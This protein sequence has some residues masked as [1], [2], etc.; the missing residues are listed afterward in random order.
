MKR[1]KGTFLLI[2]TLFL[3]LFNS[4]IN[5]VTISNQNKKIFLSEA[6]QKLLSEDPSFDF[7]I[8]L[9]M[10]LGHFPSVSSCIIKNNSIV[11]Y[12]GYGKAKIF[13]KKEPTSDTIYPIGSISKTVTATAAM[14][15]W[16]KGLFNLDDDINDYLDFNVRNPNYPDTP[17]TF[18]MLLAHHSS[19]T[20]DMNLHDLYLSFLFFTD[21]KDYPFPLIKDLIT[22]EGKFYKANIW[23]NFMPGSENIYSNFNY[24]L[25][26]HLIEVLSG[27]SFSEYCKQNIFEPLNMHNTSFYFDDLKDKELAGS[28]HNFGSIYYP[29]PYVDIGYSYGGL[30]T[31]IN[32]F[33]HY[34]L[35]YINEGMWKDFRLLKKSTIDM[36][37]TIQFE[38]TSRYNRQGIGWQRFGGYRNSSRYG[39]VGH[40]PG[41][42]GAI[43]MNIDENYAQI[44]FINRFIIFKRPR[45][46]FAWFMLCSIFATKTNEF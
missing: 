8:K 16:E 4:C 5:P 7:R 25:M 43:F 24:I 6:N 45:V 14:Q 17:I 11:W 42:S 26:E 46:L 1:V 3:L 15:L 28:Y 10:R 36:M 21:K 13:P 19:L 33:S 18:R 41:G 2:F 37:L 38:N 12:K 22:P 30:K 23:E 20:N 44:F 34:I 9:L 39:H 40:V 29:I 32:D 31:S 27:Q 35:A